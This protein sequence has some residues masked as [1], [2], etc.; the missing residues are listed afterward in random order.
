MKRVLALAL[1]LLVVSPHPLH[2]EQAAARA[3]L[4][5]THVTVIDLTGAPAQPDMTVVIGA[6]GTDRISALGKTDT[7]TI[8]PDAQVIAANGRFLIP[9]L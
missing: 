8:P 3:P 1:F 2:A 5:F 4:A 9:G 6:R 7:V